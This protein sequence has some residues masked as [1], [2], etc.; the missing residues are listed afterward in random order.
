MNMKLVMSISF[1]FLV[2]SLICQEPPKNNRAKDRRYK[3]ASSASPIESESILTSKVELPERDLPSFSAQLVKDHEE[4]FKQYIQ[5]YVR[6]EAWGMINPDSFIGTIL[7]T[8]V[9]TK[10]VKR[11]KGVDLDTARIL[12]GRVFMEDT[13]EF[14]NILQIGLDALKKQP[15]ESDLFQY[16]NRAFTILTPSELKSKKEND[17]SEALHKAKSSF[18]DLP[19]SEN[20]GNFE[21]VPDS[22]FGPFATLNLFISFCFKNGTFAPDTP[23]FHPHS[24]SKKRNSRE[25]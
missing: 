9:M 10:V 6:E 24:R 20:M 23:S 4:D 14:P 16:A 13:K 7:N 3:L 17:L 18:P 8:S 22:V 11:F 19:T 21:K 2:N 25:V 15:N 12:L 1:A 5:S